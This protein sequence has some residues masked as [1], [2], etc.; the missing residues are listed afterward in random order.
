MIYF[1]PEKRKIQGTLAP[2]LQH[3]A[4]SGGGM[5]NTETNQITA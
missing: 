5:E 2:P 3:I 1:L 4:L